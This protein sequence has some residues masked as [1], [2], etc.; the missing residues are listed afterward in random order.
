[1]GGQ[2]TDG[3]SASEHC[4]VTGCAQRRTILMRAVR[5]RLEV[6]EGVSE[7]GC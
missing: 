2:R 1:M 3:A 5:R 4:V 6:V 7:L